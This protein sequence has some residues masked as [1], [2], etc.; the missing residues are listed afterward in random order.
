MEI[1]GVNL[2]SQKHRSISETNRMAVVH[3]MIL[4]IDSFF[5]EQEAMHI[6]EAVWAK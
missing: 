3:L 5:S 2:H 6:C 4:F 1:K